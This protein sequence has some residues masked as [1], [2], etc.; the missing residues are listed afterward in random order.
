MMSPDVRE[1]QPEA[2]PWTAPTFEVHGV[3]PPGGKKAGV[4]EETD[5]SS[6]FPASSGGLP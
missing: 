2:R 1:E 4:S 6:Y 5:T 3:R